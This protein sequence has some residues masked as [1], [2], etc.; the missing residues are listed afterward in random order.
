[1]PRLAPRA[2]FAFAAALAL[3][4]CG[5]TFDR[6][7]DV[8]Q[9]PKISPIQN[10]TQKPDYRPVSMPMPTPQAPPVQANSLWRPGSR[11]FFKDQRAGQVGD[12]LTVT[13]NIGDQAKLA[14]KTE[15]KRDAAE[16]LGLP[17]MFGLE[18]KFDD[19]L[20]NADGVSKGDLLKGTSGHSSTGDGSLKREETIKVQMA[21]VIIQ[22]LPNG[23]MV[24]AGRQEV[25]VNNEL[26]EVTLTG[27]IRPQ[28]IS[29][30]NTITSEKIAEARIT[31]G[32]RGTISDLQQPRYGQQVY[33]ILMPF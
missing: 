25:R 31:Y 9:A 23:N 28:D 21:A 14:N 8:G 20:P 24:I 15:G 26:R 4:A 22:V 3:S 6:L 5:N 33:D 2:A 10:P 7:S 1:M 13:V 11:A 29:S 27:V 19:L 30:G 32:G 12:I 16:S 17:N 18:K